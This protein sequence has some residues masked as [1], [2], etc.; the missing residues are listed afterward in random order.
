MEDQIIGVICVL[1]L[2]VAI[3]AVTNKKRKY[4]ENFPD[5]KYKKDRG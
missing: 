5:A 2:F 3:G 1:A 4:G